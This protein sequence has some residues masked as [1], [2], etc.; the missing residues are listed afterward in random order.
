M[1]KVVHQNLF[2]LDV[3]A[4]VNSANV[5]LLAGSGICGIIHKN[6]GKE[7]ERYCKTIGKQDYGSAIITPSFNLSPLCKY[8]IHACGPRYLDGQRGEAKLL[9]LTHQSIIN[10]AIENNL[11]SIAIPPIS[12]G[13]YR[14]P[15]E[16]A[17]QISIQ[18]VAKALS[19]S[20]YKM[21][22]YFAMKDTDKYLAY[23]EICKKFD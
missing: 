21:D 22:V 17:A 5:S 13:V 15:V 6:A 3:D 19:L 1:I 2:T 18:S 9:E 23:S 10:V 4:I 20:N 7:L 11:K 16:Q 14:F 12:T 8:I